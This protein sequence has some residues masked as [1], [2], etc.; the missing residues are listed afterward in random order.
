M[1]TVSA[2]EVISVMSLFMSPLHLLD[3]HPITAWCRNTF[4]TLPRIEANCAD[5]Q[6]IAASAGMI[7]SHAGMQPV[8][9]A[10][11]VVCSQDRLESFMRARA[12]PSRGSMIAF[13]FA[14]FS[15][16]DPVHKDHVAED[17]RQHH[18]RAHQHEDVGGRRR[19][20]LPNG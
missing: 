5:P 8:A 17:D 19:R 4:L 20:R 16:E 10:L 6:S 1:S 13:A 3:E 9:R 18:Q 11:R 2:A 14:Q 12:S 15:A 7:V